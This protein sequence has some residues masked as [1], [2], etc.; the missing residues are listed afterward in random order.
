MRP[1]NL[2]EPID[3]NAPWFHVHRWPVFNLGFRSLFL[4]GG[5]WAACSMLVWLLI[6]SGHFAWQAAFPATLW[7]AHE[8]IF[9][10]AGVVAVGF[11]LTASQNWTGA[12]TLNG[13]PLCLLT[14]IWVVTRILLL[15]SPD[16]ILMAL[17]GQSA[18]W[19]FAI[20]HFSLVLLSTNSKNNY[21][22][23][24]VLSGICIANI[25]FLL[26]I[27]FGAYSL[28]ATFTQIAVLMFT[29][30][31]GLIGGRV[32]PFFTARGLSLQDQVRT[33]KVDKLLLV[34]STIGLVGFVTANVF[35][36]PLNPGY[37]I[38]VA[39][40]LHLFRAIKWFNVGVFNV[41]LLWSLHAAYLATSFGLLWFALTFIFILPHGKD[42]LHLITVGGIGLMILAMMARVSLGH[43]SRPLKPHW[44]INFAFAVCLVAAVIRAFG[45]LFISPH[46]AWLIS[47]TLWVSS[48]ICFVWVYF[49]ILTRPRIDGRRG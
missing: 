1:I 26:L 11:L 24:Y 33:P 4:A 39:A 42:A 5:L 8:M 40:L 7:H 3:T 6:L 9:G 23:I 17:A 38:L 37:L 35:S 47:G 29:L 13:L 25:S 21:I 41:P 14:C 45:P 19:L 43:T 34:A 30:L 28:A 46:V 10:F 31:I 12:T 36:G 32:I 18:F 49:P 48:F 15:V 44:L 20:C 2:V 27:A 22:F 16:P